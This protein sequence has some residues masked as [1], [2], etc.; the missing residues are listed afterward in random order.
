MMNGY[1][2]GFGGVMMVLVWVFVVALIVWLVL[3]LA[4]SQSQPG[5]TSS[6]T[7]GA[8]RILQERLARGEIDV[9]EYRLRRAALEGGAR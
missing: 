2:Y 7:N 1:G 5:S 4:R 6:P 9:E 8:L 3:T